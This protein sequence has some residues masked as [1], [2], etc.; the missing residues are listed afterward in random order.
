MYDPV[1]WIEKDVYMFLVKWCLSI[2]YALSTNEPNTILYGITCYDHI[3]VKELKEEGKHNAYTREEAESL[4]SDL[5]KHL[6][7]GG[8][9]FTPDYNPPICI[10]DDFSTN[11][12]LPA[13]ELYGEYEVKWEQWGIYHKITKVTQRVKVTGKPGE[14]HIGSVLDRNAVMALIRKLEYEAVMPPFIVCYN[15]LKNRGGMS[16]YWTSEKLEDHEAAQELMTREKKRHMW[17]DWRIYRDVTEIAANDSELSCP[18]AYVRSEG[19]LWL[20]VHHAKKDACG[21]DY[22]EQGFYN[23][24]C[25]VRREIVQIREQDMY[26]VIGIY[27]CV[28]HDPVP[29]AEAEQKEEESP[30]E[31]TPGQMKLLEERVSLL[32]VIKEVGNSNIAVYLKALDHL[33][34]TRTDTAAGS[35]Y[36]GDQWVK[37]CRSGMAIALDILTLKIEGVTIGPNLPKHPIRIRYIEGVEERHVLD[38]T[39]ISEDG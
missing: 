16:I 7:D 38:E 2:G 1:I 30:A 36:Y 10:H 6:E 12:F 9:S 20:R 23:D 4:I 35:Y 8:E 5:K 28:H 13:L 29:E 25:E 37:G 19:W 27:A 26:A 24:M 39:I 17:G 15:L 32:E 18:P 34:N 3:R 33:F 22:E 14:L 31:V 21:A 11:V